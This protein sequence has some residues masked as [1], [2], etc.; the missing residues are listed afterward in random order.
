MLSDPAVATVTG[1]KIKYIYITQINKR[2]QEQ[3]PEFLKSNLK[4]SSNGVVEYSQSNMKAETVL[5]SLL[6]RVLPCF[7]LLY[8]ILLV[9]KFGI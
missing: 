2:S 7:I 1:K 4:L 9:I 8:R 6:C 5:P 3:K